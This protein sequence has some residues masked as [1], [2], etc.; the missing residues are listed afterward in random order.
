MH[1]CPLPYAPLPLGHCLNA[2]RPRLGVRRGPR[3]RSCCRTRRPGGSGSLKGA[4]RAPSCVGAVV[5]A[6]RS[7]SS[8]AEVV[9]EPV[10]APTR[11]RVAGVVSLSRGA[12]TRRGEV[13]PRPMPWEGR[14]VLPCWGASCGVRRLRSGPQSVPCPSRARPAPGGLAL[15]G[16]R[17]EHSDATHPPCLCLAPCQSPSPTSHW[18][19]WHPAVRVVP[20]WVAAVGFREARAP[21]S[22]ASNPTKACRRRLPASARPSL[23]LP[24]APDARRSASFIRQ[25]AGR[26]ET[27]TRRS[28]WGTVPSGPS[29]H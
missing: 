14:G 17:A 12:R 2:A 15:P 27:D 8:V 22:G 10:R 9:S 5:V 1:D 29:S 19:W 16:G 21:A 24:A 18:A 25:E 13:V 23:P 28:P 3:R 11:T 20:A 6:P 26:Q 4:A 7:G